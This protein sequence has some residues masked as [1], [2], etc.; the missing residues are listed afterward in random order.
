MD[1]FSPEFSSKNYPLPRKSERACSPYTY[2]GLGGQDA[3]AS[4]SVGSFQICKETAH[5]GKIKFQVK[6]TSIA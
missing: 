6:K 2:P 5:A 3:M 4:T 1:P